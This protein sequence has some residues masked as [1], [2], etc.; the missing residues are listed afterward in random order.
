MTSSPS[1]FTRTTLAAV[2]ERFEVAWVHWK[3]VHT[4]LVAGAFGIL[5]GAALKPRK[6]EVFL[7]ALY[8][9]I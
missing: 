6:A 2:C 9:R 4:V 5:T 3:V 7:K 8:A 1:T